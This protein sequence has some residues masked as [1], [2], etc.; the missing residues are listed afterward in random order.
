MRQC[1]LYVWYFRFST[2]SHILFPNISFA[3]LLKIYDIVEWIYVLSVKYT[4]IVSYIR[5]TL[6]DGY[7]NHKCEI[8]LGK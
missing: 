4:I 5:T 7:I 3:G 1:T 8:E 2:L 6:N